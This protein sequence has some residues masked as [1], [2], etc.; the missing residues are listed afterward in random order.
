MTTPTFPTSAAITRFRP[1]IEG[2]YLLPQPDRMDMMRHT[3]RTKAVRLSHCGRK[4]GWL[5]ESVHQLVVQIRL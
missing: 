3:R 5:G 1:A 4:R 2:A